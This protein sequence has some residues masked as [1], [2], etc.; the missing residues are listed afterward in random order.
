MRLRALQAWRRADRLPLVS[1]DFYAALSQILRERDIISDETGLAAYQPAY[2]HLGLPTPGVVVVPNSVPELRA[3]VRVCLDHGRTWRAIGG[4][5]SQRHGV[6]MQ[7]PVDVLISTGRLNAIQSVDPSALTVRVACG[8]TFAAIDHLL[9]A[10]GL[11][12]PLAGFGPPGSTIGGAL[13]TRA[14]GSA[15]WGRGDLADQVVSARVMMATGRELDFASDRAASGL[16]DIGRA[17]LDVADAGGLI[18]EAELR[19][20]AK[21]AT[22]AF[23]VAAFDDIAQALTWRPPDAPPAGLA[24][25]W[26]VFSHPV[27]RALNARPGWTDACSNTVLSPRPGCLPNLSQDGCV[28][29]LRLAGLT[30]EVLDLKK[31]W[32]EDLTQAG[33]RLSDSPSHDDTGRLARA[34]NDQIYLMPTTPRAIRDVEVPPGRLA[35]YAAAISDA[36]T[37][38]RECVGLRLSAFDGRTTLAGPAAG[39]QNGSANASGAEAGRSSFLSRSVDLA[40]AFGGA[41]V[42]DPRARAVAID[43][44]GSHSA[45]YD[46]GASA[47]TAFDTAVLNALRSQ[48]SGQSEEAG[49]GTGLAGWSPTSGV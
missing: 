41:A 11:A 33:A 25:S 36:F 49:D 10:H 5:T 12:L 34:L 47:D 26:D 15:T 20:A 24:V 23:V 37:D 13:A 35:A 1:T 2:A 28:G 44:A 32:R 40:A 6:A 38:E 17:L 4:A 22:Q 39:S 31:A 7:V 45:D 21:P 29:V 27:V 18:L 42:D 48:A 8:A 30:D 16:P 9:M 43:S 14:H 46:G 3:I 19:V